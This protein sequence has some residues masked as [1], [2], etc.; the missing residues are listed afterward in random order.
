[1]EG[2]DDLHTVDLVFMPNKR[3]SIAL[4]YG[5]FGKVLNAT[6]NK[7]GAIQVKWLF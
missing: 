1:M 5:A 6:D 2:E 4:V 3:L 7:V